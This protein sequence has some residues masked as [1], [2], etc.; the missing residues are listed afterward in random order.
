[1]LA[2]P[3]LDF[4]RVSKPILPKVMPGCVLPLRIFLRMPRQVSTSVRTSYR[5]SPSICKCSGGDEGPFR[6]PWNVTFLRMPCDR[7]RLASMHSY[8]MSRRP[9]SCRLVQFGSVRPIRE[10]RMNSRKGS[11]PMSYCVQNYRIIKFNEY[12]LHRGL[13]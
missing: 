1:M 11:T 6:M 5:Y 8:A 4:K 12:L 13:K 7:K 10:Y 3:A 9:A 2:V